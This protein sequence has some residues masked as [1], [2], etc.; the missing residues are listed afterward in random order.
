MVCAKGWYKLIQELTRVISLIPC[1][2][3]MIQALTSVDIEVEEFVD[4]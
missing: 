1:R 2:Y 3:L 4:G